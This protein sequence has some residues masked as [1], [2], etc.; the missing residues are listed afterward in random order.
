MTS[1]HTQRRLIWK[2]SEILLCVFIIASHAHTLSEG[3][4]QHQEKQQSPVHR[5]VFVGHGITTLYGIVWGFTSSLYEVTNQ[6]AKI[7]FYCSCQTVETQWWS[8]M[9]MVSQV[10]VVR[11]TWSFPSCHPELNFSF[12]SCSVFMQCKPWPKVLYSKSKNYFLTWSVGICIKA[13][14][15]CEACLFKRENK[16]WKSRWTF[17]Q[18]KLWGH[19]GPERSV[20][21]SPQTEQHRKRNKHKYKSIKAND[22]KQL[23]INTFKTYWLRRSHKANPICVRFRQRLNQDWNK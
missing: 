13:R 14:K 15:C 21:D 16:R 19:W 1:N 7:Y 18:E 22:W 10:A 20:F 5:I 9:K 12:R 17:L 4:E 6:V 8:V 2:D 3:S 23:N 11:A